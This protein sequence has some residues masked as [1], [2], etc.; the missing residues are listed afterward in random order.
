MDLRSILDFTW[1]SVSD[2]C[3]HA[4]DPYWPKRRSIQSDSVHLEA[5]VAWLMK[6]IDKVDGNGSS[7]A[8]RVLNGW[9]APYP[10]TS[11]YLIETLLR[12]Q[13][14]YADAKF[15]QAASRIGDWELSIQFEDGGFVGKELGVLNRPVVFNT[16]MV[17]LG[18]NA[19][20]ARTREQKYL[21][22]GMRAGEFLVACM[23]EDGCFVRNLHNG[24]IHTYNVRAAW[25]LI[26]LGFLSARPDFIEAGRKNVEWSLAQ[27]LEN[28]YFLHNHFRAGQNALTHSIGY[29]MR[30]ILEA[31]LL[32]GE[33]RYLDCVRKTADR[34][35]AVY[36]IRKR[37][38]AELDEDWKEVRPHLC[39]TGYAQIALNLLKLFRITGEVKYLNTALHLID[40]VKVQQP[41]DRRLEYFGG[42]K[43]SFPVYGRYAPL[44]FPNWAAKFF[45]DALLLKI[46]VMRDYEN[47]LLDEL[48][49]RRQQALEAGIDAGA[50]N[51]PRSRRGVREKEHLE[52]FGHLF[53]P[54]K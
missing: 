5:A 15:L 41:L 12:L 35:V 29:V 16:G 22:A 9:M 14:V 48:P 23:D 3:K 37:L 54:Q 50:G 46:E 33:K 28:G 1:L 47:S 31:Y 24:L 17:L 38:V 36:G 8:Y 26:Q 52:A 27:Q 20:F 13:D 40:D 4:L 53:A 42:I 11:G 39:L 25:G 49:P 18:L 19:L 7:K 51:A 30:G 32:L 6:S 34:L 44:Q 45:V 2:A 10:E 21:A 43:G